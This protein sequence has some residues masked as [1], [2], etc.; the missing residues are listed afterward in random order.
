MGW[1]VDP[2]GLR[3]LLLRIRRDYGD[4]PIY[5]TENGA[6]YDDRPTPD[7][8][9]VA[10]LRAEIADEVAD[11]DALLGVPVS[12]RWGYEVPTDGSTVR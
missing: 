8:A 4:R 11:L 5:V 7:P 9:T 12:R 3:D 1:S 2:T 6:A 10:R